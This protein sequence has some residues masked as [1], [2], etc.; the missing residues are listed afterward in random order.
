MVK[1]NYMRKYLLPILLIGFWSCEKSSEVEGIPHVLIRDIDS[2]RYIYQ[3]LIKQGSK[4]AGSGVF[5]LTDSIKLNNVDIDNFKI[6]SANFNRVKIDSNI[7]YVGEFRLDK[8]HGDGT[9]F[10]TDG[11]K[12]VGK[13]DNDIRIEGTYYWANGGVF[14]GKW[15]NDQPSFGRQIYKKAGQIWEGHFANN[16]PNGEGYFQYLNGEQTFPGE[17]KDGSM[18]YVTIKLFEI[19]G[20]EKETK[21]IFAVQKIDKVN[22]WYDEIWQYVDGF[23]IPFY[24]IDKKNN[25]YAYNLNSANLIDRG[26]SLD[27]IVFKNNIKN[28][29]SILFKNDNLEFLVN[30][31]GTM[32]NG[33]GGET[34]IKILPNEFDIEVRFSKEE[35]FEV[36]TQDKINDTKEKFLKKGY[37]LKGDTK[38]S[39]GK[40]TDKNLTPLTGMVFHLHD[41]GNLSELIEYR[42]GVKI[43]DNVK[44]YYENGSKKYFKSKNNETYY[45]DNGKKKSSKN[46]NTRELKKYYPNGKLKLKGQY[47]IYDGHTGTWVEYYDN[48]KVKLKYNHDKYD[49]LTFFHENGNRAEERKIGWGEIYLSLG[50]KQING[51]YRKTTQRVTVTQDRICFDEND[52]KCDCSADYDDRDHAFNRPLN[53]SQSFGCSKNMK[54]IDSDMIPD[55]SFRNSVYYM[56]RSEYYHPDYYGKY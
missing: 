47:N 17:A 27:T 14:S 22:G 24:L 1:E 28:I 35:E 11:D 12:F 38:E 10:Y 34:H 53:Y 44:T 18:V 25:K 8:K 31:N 36:L 29:E 2:T 39:K 20:T 5:A 4:E 56:F 30:Q 32:K 48:G 3:G 6:D 19:K 42:K 37:V 51:T 52:N 9:F 49:W 23:K 55:N 7:K 13:Y 54:S 21:I 43:D 26:T 16:L 41:N 50:E 40:I 15:K 45:Y 33:S 46:L